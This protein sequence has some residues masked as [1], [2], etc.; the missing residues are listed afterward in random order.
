M[1]TEQLETSLKFSIRIPINM[2][3]WSFQVILC[4]RIITN[5]PSYET[6]LVFFKWVIWKDKMVP[7][8]TMRTFFSPLSVYQN[9]KFWGF[10]VFVFFFILQ[11]TFSQFCAACSPH[12]PQPPR[13]T[14]H[15]L[16][17]Q[18]QKYFKYLCINWNNYTI[19]ALSHLLVSSHKI[20]TFI[21]FH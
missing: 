3:V 18:T 17:V 14:A 8:H 20:R 1:F 21:F 2:N 16:W 19:P 5:C 6:A 4:K 10:F 9:W 12:S 15:S 7:L 11:N 13:L